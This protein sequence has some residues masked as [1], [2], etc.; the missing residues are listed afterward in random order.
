[1]GSKVL[2]ANEGADAHTPHKPSADRGEHIVQFYEAE[3]VLLD[4]LKGFIGLA[5]QAGSSAIVVATETHLDSLAKVLTS[6]GINLAAAAKE[7]RYVALN[8]ADTLSRFMVDGSPNPQ[9]FNKLIRPVIIRASASS[10]NDPRVAIFSE[11]VALLWNERNVESAIQ[12]EGLWKELAKSQSFLLYCAYP[13]N[14]LNREEYGKVF[15]KICDQHSFVIPSDAYTSLKKNEERLRG[16]ADLQQKVEVMQTAAEFRLSEERFRRLIDGVRDYAIFMLDTEGRVCSWNQGAER[17]KGYKAAEIIGKHFSCFYLEEDLVAGKPRRE[18]EIALRE[19]R[20]EDEGW[21]LRKDGSKFWATIVITPIRDESGELI[22]FSKIAK[23]NTERMLVLKALR[24]SRREL[25]E[26]EDSLRRLSLHL[27][28]TQ[29]DERRRIGRDLHDSLGQT[30]SVLKMNLDSLATSINLDSHDSRNQNVAACAN[31]AEDCI[32]EVRTIAYLLHPP[33]LEEMGLKSA[34]SWYLDGFSKR[35][36]IRTTFDIPEEFGRLPRHV[37]TAIFRVL[38]ES[39]T[40][41]HRH[42]GS[43]VAHVR[44]MTKGGA[45]IL[46]VSDEGKGLPAE[47]PGESRQDGLHVLGVGLRG[48]EERMRQLGGGLELFSS[49]RGTTVIASVPVELSNNATASA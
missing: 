25:H 33:M 23:D 47:S 31:L 30:L 5:L 24:D 40:N 43:V 36:G 15:L 6:E 17:I 18:I 7:G 49:P 12:L 9:R 22:G 27:L 21:R 2:N 29:D 20:V 19:G 32:K 4:G 10:R 28:R 3:E 8:A 1:M 41:V 34:I 13:I 35:S 11:M 44:V 48:M 26:S 16:I 39:L 42:S 38:Q 46:E 14:N 37:E 45:T